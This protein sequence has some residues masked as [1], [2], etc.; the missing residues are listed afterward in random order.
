MM[1]LF[2]ALGVVALIGLGVMM[3]SRPAAVGAEMGEQGM[4]R[5]LALTKSSGFEHS[6]IHRENGELGHA[7]KILMELAAKNNMLMVIT[8]DAGMINEPQLK[9]FDVVLFYTTG[10]LTER[11]TDNN[12]PMSVAGRQ[13]LMDYVKNGG[14]FVGTH[15]TTD[16]FHGWEENGEKPFSKMVGGEFA[17]HGKQQKAELQVIKHPITANLPAKWELLDEYYINKNVTGT[18]TTLITLNTKSME[19]ER[20]TQLDPYPITWCEQHGK[21]RVFNTPLGH[22]EDVWTNPMYQDLLVRGIQWA[23]GR[24]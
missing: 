13:A 17:S 8:K 15:T 10:E 18:F 4:I 2:V 23:A 22:R 9:Q 24:L 21:G 16:T 6:V 11:G 3:N 20:Y 5:V 12:S 14:G 7:E 1:G 19:E